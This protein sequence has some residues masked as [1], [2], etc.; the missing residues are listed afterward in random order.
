MNRAF[1]HSLSWYKKSDKKKG[2]GVEPAIAVV[3]T[4]LLLAFG[5]SGT[6][7]G[8][9]GDGWVDASRFF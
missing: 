4:K 7:R 3:P 9:F 2:G 5:L 6:L 8:D 1:C